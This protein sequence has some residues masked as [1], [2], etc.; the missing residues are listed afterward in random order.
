MSNFLSRV[1]ATLLPAQK[2]EWKKFL[3]M[4]LML[5]LICFDYSLLRALKDTLVVNGKGSGAEVLPYLKFWAILPSAILMTWLFTRLSSRMN[6]HQVFTVITLG[7]LAYFALFMTVIYPNRESLHPHDFA[8][9]LFATLGPNFNGLVA[10]VRNWTF[11]S[12]YVVSELWGTFM[13][14][15]LFWGFANEV[16]RTD[17]AERFYG[18]SHIGS[19]IATTIAGDL[20]ILLSQVTYHPAIPFG[21]DGYEQGAGMMLIAVIVGGLLTLATYRWMVKHVLTDPVYYSP[22]QAEVSTC[23]KKKR[24]SFRDCIS[25]I[26]KSRYLIAI[27]V[28]VIGYNLMINL[29]ETIFK[30]R[31]HS[32]YPDKSDFQLCLS[33]ITMAIG[34]ISTTTALF[35]PWMLKR[36][37]FLFTS[38]LSPIILIATAIIFFTLLYTPDDW[39]TPM[40]LSVGASVPALIVSVGCAQ[41]A[42]SKSA[43]YTLFDTTK[44][45]A[46]IPL[47]S[48]EKMKSKA[49]IDGI[50]SRLGKS[51]GSLLQ[52]GLIAACGG[53]VAAI[54]TPAIG[55]L[56]VVS[57]AW[58]WGTCVMGRGYEKLN[59]K[60]TATEP[61]VTSEQQ[62][63]EEP[64]E[65]AAIG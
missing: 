4:F 19:N 37:G 58:L 33:Q 35:V 21:A 8:D 24:M 49:A 45:M 46:F 38:L 50:G 34:I 7:F 53:S 43:K 18:M 51:G 64:Q 56:L 55:I 23:K 59:G 14:G 41:N 3:P 15:V 9:W 65:V 54:T 48:D 27:A 40:A 29:I 2:H 60:S 57:V 32:F 6:R 13:L 52:Q 42:L 63:T 20:G 30:D 16:T 31:L 26:L 1:R 28:I 17:E 36:L 39:L 61:P 11:T 44:E 22:S 25:C 5:F 12:F 62:L 10:M 47:S